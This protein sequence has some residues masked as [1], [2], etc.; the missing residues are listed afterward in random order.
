MFVFLIYYRAVARIHPKAPS[1]LLQQ[2]YLNI[3]RC[4]EASEDPFPLLAFLLD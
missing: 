2:I 4:G 3:M 1:P